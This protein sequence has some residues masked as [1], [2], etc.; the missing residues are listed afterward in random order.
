[1]EIQPI[2]LSNVSGEI[3][4]QIRNMIVEGKLTP[5]QRLPTERELSKLFEVGRSSVRE[6]MMALTATGSIIRSREGT[7][8]NPN[9]AVM[10]WSAINRPDLLTIGT[11]SDVFEARELFEIG[12]VALAAERGTP[13]HLAELVKWS[14]AHVAN[15][16]EFI[17]VDVQFHLALVK[18]T[19]NAFLLELYVRIQD[20]LFQTHN[21]YSALEEL[22]PA[23]SARMVG[24]NLAQHRAI[25]EAVRN[26]DAEAASAAMVAHFG[27]LKESMHTDPK[28][29]AT[30]ES[31][32]TEE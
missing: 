18:A 25:T 17:T 8:V 29:L 4:K 16:Q 32:D 9:P 24:E 30:A 11:I 22:S 10:T 3:A 7:F 15:V 21:Y 27:S 13:E 1:M 26:K 23:A 6:A 31:R 12:I 20:L 19:G 2:Q 14:P 5:G 28:E